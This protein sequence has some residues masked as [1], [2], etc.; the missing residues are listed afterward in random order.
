MIIPYFG[1]R[2][3]DS[4]KQTQ[5]S[6]LPKIN[7]EANIARISKDSSLQRALFRFH[8]SSGRATIDHDHL[9]KASYGASAG[10][11]IIVAMWY[12]RPDYH[13]KTTNDPNTAAKP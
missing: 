10:A 9:V 2:V 13:T 8:V 7:M 5:A 6:T 4:K 11:R 1:F 12:E 3:L